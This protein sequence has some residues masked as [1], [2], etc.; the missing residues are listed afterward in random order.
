M[1]PA[2]YNL[3]FVV[4]LVSAATTSI[5]GTLTARQESRLHPVYRAILQRFL[6][7]NGQVSAS[8]PELSEAREAIIYTSKPA[9]L[10]LAGMQVQSVYDGFATALVRPADLLYLSLSRKM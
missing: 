2:K 5:G 10:R 4:M 3:L 1:N 6:D 7:V 9:A 8:S